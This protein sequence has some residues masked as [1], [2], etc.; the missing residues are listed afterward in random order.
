MDFEIDL[1]KKLEGKKVLWKDP[2]EKKPNLESFDTNYNI[3]EFMK[4][5]NKL[6]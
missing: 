3:V 1:Y 6:K 2:D 4:N 5:N